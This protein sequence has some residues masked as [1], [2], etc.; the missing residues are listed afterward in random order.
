[1]SGA[2]LH[3]ARAALAAGAGLVKLVA[4]RETIT[5]AQA[6]LPDVLT[7]ESALGETLEPAAVEALEGADAVVLGPGLGREPRSTREQF[8]RQV[9]AGRPVPTVV[10]ADALHL[11]R[12]DVPTRNRAFVCTPHLGEVRALAGDALAAD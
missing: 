12:G 6:S 4:T 5:A 3:A 2:A 9:L 11:F 1:M 10:D 7:V 8:V